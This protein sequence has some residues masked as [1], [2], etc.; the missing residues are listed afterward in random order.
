MSAETTRPPAAFE[1]LDEEVLADVCNRVWQDDTTRA[2]E[3]SALMV[4]VHQQEVF[5]LG[6][7]TSQA[8]RRHV[9]ELVRTV[10]GVRAIHNHLVADPE[11]VAEV[12]QALAADPC[13]RLAVLGVGAFHG[14]IHLSG[15]VP[16]LAA[17][18]AADEVAS[19][20][21]HVRGV[22]AL[23][24]LPGQHAHRGENRRP[25]QPRVGQAVYALDGPAGLIEQVVICPA[26]RL[27]SHIV[28]AGNL[29]IDWR[30]IRARWLVATEAVARANDSGLFLSERL[31]ALAAQ[32]VVHPADL[33]QPPPDWTPPF[34]YSPGDVC[35]LVD[36]EPAPVMLLA[37]E[38]MP[39]PWPVASNTAAVS[40]ETPVS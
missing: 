33:R 30:P 35:W 32:P 22:L 20:V 15:E 17:R 5:L 27:V 3:R 39:A 9:D 13:T 38:L 19:R 31:D 18:L 7:V 16:D 40:L 29:E 36:F 25:L 4:E 12:A 10:P 11:L 23:P 34:P 1:H 21:G 24:H 37:S 6:H 2:S 28:I 26:S 14:W 8:Y